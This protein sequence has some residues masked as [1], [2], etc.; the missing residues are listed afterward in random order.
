MAL[1][2]KRPLLSLTSVS[3]ES[4]YRIIWVMSS[5]YQPALQPIKKKKKKETKDF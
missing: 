1:S 4:Y 2:G 5:N 3:F